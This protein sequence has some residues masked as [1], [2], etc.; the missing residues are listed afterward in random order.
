MGSKDEIHIIRDNV[1]S[2]WYY[3]DQVPTDLE[4][5]VQRDSISEHQTE[6]L[7]ESPVQRQAPVKS[8]V[9]AATPPISE[10]RS[11]SGIEKQD[12][13][14]NAADNAAQLPPSGDNS[15]PAA[16]S[17]SSDV[18][19]ENREEQ[20]GVEGEADNSL[21][22]AAAASSD[23]GIQD[24]EGMTKLNDADKPPQ[25]EPRVDSPDSIIITPEC[26]P[27]ED[28]TGAKSLVENATDKNKGNETGGKGATQEHTDHIDMSALDISISSSHYT[29]YECKRYG[30]VV[31][32]ENVKRNRD[33]ARF[34]KGA[35]FRIKRP[36]QVLHIVF[37]G[38]VII[39]C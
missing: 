35:P 10:A 15:D 22:D 28:I 23:G 37:V 30:N 26:S 14:N 11:D 20:S 29:W 8:P 32:S 31:T 24:P 17:P 6:T 18:V 1:G 27:A 3:S 9:P 33:G 5:A 12:A 13:L 4:G 7:I 19:G 39:I 34:I 2:S 38:Y 21:P 36:R 16:V 25:V